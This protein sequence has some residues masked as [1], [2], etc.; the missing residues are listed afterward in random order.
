MQQSAME[1]WREGFASITI[2]PTAISDVLGQH[3]IHKIRSIAFR[4][5]LIF[6]LYLF[7]AFQV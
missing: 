1:C 2:P 5:A 3:K 4:A 6:E 7:Q